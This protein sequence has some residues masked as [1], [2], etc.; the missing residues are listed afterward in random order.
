M[1]H[2]LITYCCSLISI[3]NPLHSPTKMYLFI[4]L[5]FVY[6]FIYC[7]F[8][9]LFIF[10]SPRTSY[11]YYECQGIAWSYLR[12]HMYARTRTHIHTHTNPRQAGGW[13]L[14][15]EPHRT[16]NARTHVL[17]SLPAFLP[18]P[19]VRCTYTHTHTRPRTGR[20]GGVWLQ[21]RHLMT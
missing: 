3:Y 4:Y 1:L 14:G 21:A 15:T 5:I 11:E 20:W 13:S 10:I 2:T 6:Y 16:I 7:L 9:L 12:S 17:T 19:A 8:I 18:Q